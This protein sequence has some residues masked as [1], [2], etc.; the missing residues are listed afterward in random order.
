MSSSNPGP[1]IQI[2]VSTRRSL[3]HHIATL[4]RTKLSTR[5]MQVLCKGC[6]S[7]VSWQMELV[8]SGLPSCLDNLVYSHCGRVALFLP[9]HLLHTAYSLIIKV[10]FLVFIA[11]CRTKALWISSSRGKPPSISRPGHKC[12]RANARECACLEGLQGKMEEQ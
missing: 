4:T 8:T 10:A 2:L 6:A 1:I 7:L 9:Q 12:S 5:S 11:R 3:R